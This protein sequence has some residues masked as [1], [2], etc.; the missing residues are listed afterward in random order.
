MEEGWWEYCEAGQAGC[1]SGEIDVGL[2]LI[3]KVKGGS[4]DDFGDDLR[5]RLK[6]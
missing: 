2:F 6:N 5:L 3:C 1:T 4:Q